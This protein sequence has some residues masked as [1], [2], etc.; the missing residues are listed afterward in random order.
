MQLLYNDLKYSFNIS[1]L[2]F[3]TPFLICSIYPDKLNVCLIISTFCN[4]LTLVFLLFYYKIL[5]EKKNLTIYAYLNSFLY[6]SVVFSFSIY[7]LFYNMSQIVI[8]NLGE[9]K[10]PSLKEV[11]CISSFTIYFLVSFTL[12]TYTKDVI[13]CIVMIYFNVSFLLA[14][15]IIFRNVVMSGII[16]FL[17]ILGIAITLYKHRKAAFGF[18]N[19]DELNNILHLRSEYKK[20]S[21]V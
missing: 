18:E 14:T 11:L 3:A 4:L 6:T 5:K 1:Q 8:F 17:S 16:I 2:F 15:H 9:D 12:L 19:D 7:S 10:M 21:L 13:F 20:S